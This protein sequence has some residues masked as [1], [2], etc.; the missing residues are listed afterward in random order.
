MTQLSVIFLWHMH[1]P[2]YK[3]M[4]QGWCIMPW[5]RLH[6][7]KGYMDMA[8]AVEMVPGA[9]VTFN[10]TPC[11]IRQLQDYVEG[12]TKDDF[13]IISEKP[14]DELSPAERV[15]VLR[16][17]FMVNW[18]VHVR[19]YGEYQRLLSKR[20]TQQNPDFDQVQKK[21]TDSEIRDLIVWYNLTWFGWAAAEKYPELAE[22]KRK[23]REFSEE[24]K[25]LVLDRQARV[26]AE[27]IPFYQRLWES[28]QI[29]VSTTPMYHPILPLLYD[30]VLADRAHPGV[31][32]PPRFRHPEDAAAQ[33]ERGLKLMEETFH[34]RPVG[35]WPSEGSVAAELTP[36][37][38]DNNVRWIATDE[39]LL[40]KRVWTQ[41]RDEALFHPWKVNDQGRELNV[42]FRDLGLSDLIGFNYAKQ[43]PGPAADDLARRLREIRSS[44]SRIGHDHAVVT[45]AL[46]GENPWEAYPDGGRIFLTR[47]YQQLT[48]AE[49]LEMTTP[50]EYLSK[51]PPSRALDQLATGSWIRANFDIWIGGPEENKAWDYLRRVRDEMPALLEQAP[52]GVAEGAWDSLY[53]AEGSDWFWWYGDTFQ[54]E[55]KR[56]FD[57]LFRMHLKNIYVVLGTE[58]PQFLNESV[59]FAHP[60]QPAEEPMDLISATID[61]KI[62]DYFEWQGAGH[63]AIR[64]SQ[65]AMYQAIMRLKDMYYGFDLQNFF[66]RLDPAEDKNNNEGLDV[67]IQF[68]GPRNQVIMFPFA[69]PELARIFDEAED[70]TLVPRGEVSSIAARKIIELKVPF[71]VLGLKVGDEVDFVVKIM[72]RELEVE[73]H[74]RDGFISFKVPD[75]GFEAR[76]W[77][78]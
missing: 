48:T 17:F 36:I 66:L 10:L 1:Q 55:V 13:Q 30:T 2:Y 33:V 14:A 32:L 44:I 68:L 18:D 6:A 47:L 38:L 74:P 35:M 28:G 4:V 58:P 9:K 31:K 45:I 70:G 76:Y 61:G 54:S 21:F 34:R 11:L 63:L 52:Q 75:E 12:H 8:K 23:G 39:H 15:F 49:G 42:F 24:D 19:P 3:D 29:E 73:R 41:R 37:F 59:R 78:V 51:H 25:A 50:S 43:P 65:G 46:D 22:L 72:E 5:V 40:W 60:V 56:E 64:T 67:Y 62:T 27:I 69:Q 53:A 77:S 57:F 26:M 16:H 71:A 7:I 20:G